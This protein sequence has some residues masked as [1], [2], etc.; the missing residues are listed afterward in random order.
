MIKYHKVSTLSGSSQYRHRDR[1][2]SITAQV[3]H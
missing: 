1:P 3:P 2:G